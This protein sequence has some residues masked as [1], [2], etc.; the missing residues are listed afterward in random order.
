[1]I[2][3]AFTPPTGAGFAIMGAGSGGGP[4]VGQT[5]SFVALAAIIAGLTLWTAGYAARMRRAVRDREGDALVSWR[6][7]NRDSMSRKGSTPVRSD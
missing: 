1:M 4:R 7:V 2:A 3:K 5:G 6:L